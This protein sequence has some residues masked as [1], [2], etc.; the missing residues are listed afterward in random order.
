MKMEI[1]ANWTF[2]N[3]SVAEE[4]DRHVREQL[5][6]YDLV[7]GAVA[8]FARHYIPE[9]GVVYDVGASTG[10]VGRAIEA[11]VKARRASFVAIESSVEMASR[12][13]GP[14]AM[15]VA[16]AI[17][18]PFDDFD[19]AICFLIIM[20]LPVARRRAW[21]QGLMQ[22]CRPGGAIILVD[23]VENPGGYF[24]TA[25]ARLTLAGK[26]A[27]GTSAEDIVAKELSL[28]G[29]QRPL[30]YGFMSFLAPGAARQFFQFGDF[31]GWVIESQQR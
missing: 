21:L 8:H 5:P 31:A 14:G 19:L 24:G 28:S 23:K 15:E 13:R 16:D 12:Y 1:P 29:A 22:R 2:R 10:N 18:Y 26:L 27:T 17:T 11:T 6:W 25:L 30:E 3:Q 9:G 20:F 7:T 4:F